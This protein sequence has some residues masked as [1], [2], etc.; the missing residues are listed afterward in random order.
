M[1]TTAEAKAAAEAAAKLVEEAAVAVDAAAKV[2][3]NL[4]PSA[5]FGS[6][7]GSDKK[8]AKDVAKE[9]AAAAAAAASAAGVA[10]K[11]PIVIDTL[12]A[13][14]AQV[15]KAS[16]LVVASANKLDKGKSDDVKAAAVEAAAK[17]DILAK[18]ALEAANKLASPTLVLPA[19]A[20]EATALPAASGTV[21]SE[22]DKAMKLIKSLSDLLDATNGN[23]ADKG[24]PTFE[25]L[26]KAL[27]E[28][29]LTPAAGGSGGGGKMHRKKKTGISRRIRRSRVGANTRRSREF[30]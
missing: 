19:D 24:K 3:E 4:T 11:S 8:D 28:S 5:M 10:A 12:I 2:I 17:A 26:K 25:E 23:A 14:A 15:E 21:K 22:K 16:T 29:G 20:A 18:V 1:S 9:A 30:Y 6:L 7:G 27:T 13:A